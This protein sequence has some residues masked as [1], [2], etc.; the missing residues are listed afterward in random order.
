[1]KKRPSCGLRTQAAGVKKRPARPVEYEDLI[2]SA[3]QPVVQPEWA[4]AGSGPSPEHPAWAEHL[5]HTLLQEGLLP[6]TPAMTECRLRVWS[7]CSGINS[8]MLAL[9]AISK[10]VTQILGIHLG[11]SMYCSCDLDP[12]CLRLTQMRYRPQHLCNNIVHRNFQSGQFYCMLAKDNIALPR[13]GIDL[14]VGTYPCSPW[15]R[16]GNRLG[17][18]H[19]DIMPLRVGIQSIEYMRPVT[20]VLELG[21][22]WA[23]TAQKEI[24]Q[25][26]ADHLNRPS[27]PQMYVMETVGGL[28]PGFSGYPIQRP[29]VFVLG[30]RMDNG[31]PDAMTAPLHC[32]LA[33]PIEI[34][35]TF[36]GFLGLRRTVDWSRVGEYPTDE[37]LQWCMRSQCR[38]SP[39]AI[40]VCPVHKCKCT[41]CGDDGLGCSWRKRMLLLLPKI[42]PRAVAAKEP[43][44]LTYTQVLEMSGGTC[45]ENP[46][47]RTYMN[48]MALHQH[49]WPLND[50]LMIV[51]LSQNPPYHGSCR[52]GFVPTLATSSTPFC[53]QTGAFLTTYQVA[54]LMGMQLESINFNG[55]KENWFR[56]KIGLC[57]HPANFGT[58]LMALIAA[59]L[60][61]HVGLLPALC[62]TAGV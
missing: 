33:K 31:T 9:E 32:L 53:F 14:Y 12:E 24:Q 40:V 29:R 25:F 15:S 45:P 26:I 10:A 7:D 19:P 60:A 51:D 4:Q 37:E 2:S 13:E 21:E 16:R 44:R 59:P 6:R 36:L 57:V 11:V 38:C 23:Q 58:V 35:N 28:S 46:R 39:H 3:D 22:L 61:K 52:N 54:T 20:F 62:T 27:M 34:R 43:G 47:L 30:W 8:E 56:K 49:A 55:F 5:V 17:W 1:M 18:D 42:G 48:L 41:N 50:T